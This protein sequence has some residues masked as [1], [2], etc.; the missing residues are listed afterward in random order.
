MLSALTTPQHPILGADMYSFTHLPSLS[1]EPTMSYGCSKYGV[2][3]RLGA[4]VE[5][6][7]PYKEERK[8]NT[9]R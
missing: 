4:V 7:S 8:E 3:E 6:Q 5:G 9:Q 1:Q 2:R